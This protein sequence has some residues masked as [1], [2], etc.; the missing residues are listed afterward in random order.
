[1]ASLF[2][3]HEVHLQRGLRLTF[4]YRGITFATVAQFSTGVRPAP[5]IT[6]AKGTP[7]DPCIP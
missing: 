1:V 3:A 7:D 4:K 2:D 6:A 5:H